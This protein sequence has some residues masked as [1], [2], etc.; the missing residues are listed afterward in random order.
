MSG[1]SVTFQN[2]SVGWLT[3][4]ADLAREREV[5]R[6]A[7]ANRTKPLVWITTPLLHNRVRRCVF[8]SDVSHPHTTWSEDIGCIAR[9]SSS[10]P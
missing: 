10:R 4:M 7:Q 2:N 5:L 3:L 6:S 1:F 9:G 8:H